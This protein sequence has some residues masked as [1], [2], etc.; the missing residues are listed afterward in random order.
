[1]LYENEEKKHTHKGGVFYNIGLFLFNKGRIEEALLFIHRALKED[2]MKHVGIGNF[3]KVDSY[4]IITLDKTL[5]NPVINTAIDFISNQ[6]LGTY[7]F[8]GRS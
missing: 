2:H 1:M 7:T 3:P 6:F 4:K 5:N 8:D